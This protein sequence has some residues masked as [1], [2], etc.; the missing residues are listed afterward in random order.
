DTVFVTINQ[1]PSRPIIENGLDTL[2]FCK[3]DAPIWL[4]AVDTNADTTKTQLF[5]NNAS[6]NSDSLD[7]SIYP[8]GEYTVYSKNIFT[9]CVSERDTIMAY[10]SNSIEFQRF[11]DTINVCH[12]ETVNLEDEVVR[13]LANRNNNNYK[14]NIGHKIWALIGT[15]PN[16]LN[17]ATK[18]APKSIKTEKDVQRFY[19]EVLDSISGCFL[20]DTATVVF[21]EL[22]TIQQIDPIVICQFQDTLL[23][24]PSDVYKYEWFRKDHSQI[25][26]PEKLQL[27]KSE[28]IK[29]VA[30]DKEWGCV[31]S[32]FVK[33]DVKR[34]PEVALAEGE[35]FC[36][37]SGMHPIVAKINPSQDNAA[38]DLTIQWR[39]GKDVI[40]TPI[41]TDTIEVSGLSK[42]IHYTIRQTNKV[43]GCYKDTLIEV[44]VNRALR[45]AM[46]D[47]ERICQPDSIAFK[48]EVENYIYTNTADI[49]LP[50]VQDIQIEYARIDNGNAINLSD[51]QVEKLGYIEGRD[52]VAYIYT[53]TDA[54]KVCSASDT[55]FVTINQK[56]SRPIIENGSDT[57]FFCGDLAEI[58]I[59]AKDVNANPNE[60][61]IFWGEYAS[62]IAGDSLN[63]TAKE[64]RYTAF[65]QNIFTE[66]V[67]ELDTIVAVIS[68]PITV[69][70]IGNNGV[71]ELCAGEHINVADRG[72]ASFSIA[73]RWNSEVTFIAKADGNITNIVN[74]TDVTRTHQDTIV[75]EFSAID[76]LTGC[77]AQNT[78]TL[79]FH[80]KP[81]FEIEGSTILCQGDELSLNAIGDTR[82][83][84]YVWQFEGSDIVENSTAQFTKKGLMNDTTIMVIAQ[85]NGT[86]CIDTL[87]QLIKIHETPQT[88]ADQTFAFC[89]VNGNTTETILLERSEEDKA[90]FSLQW[91]DA[92]MQPIS[93]ENELSL[94]IANDTIYNLQVKQMNISK[95]IT[96]Q[97]ELSN[98]TVNVSKHINV[99]LRD[100]NICMP[101]RFNLAKYAKEGK[102]ESFSGYGLEIARIFKMEGATP[103]NVADSTQIE[104][105]GLYHI[106]Y[107]DNNSCETSADV[108][109]KFISKP[110]I[111]T[112]EESMP[113]Y[114][115]QGI[116][117][118]IS[119]KFIAGNYEY[120]WDKMGANET[121][122]SDSLKVNAA[123][124]NGSSVSYKVWRRDTIY[125]CESEKA[126]IAYQILDSI[127]TNLAETLH[128]CET[129]SIDLDSV[130]GH[131][132]TSNND[133]KMSIYHS[134]AT[135]KKGSQLLY[136][137]AVSEEGYYLIEAQDQ[138]SGCKAKNIVEIAK[139]AAPTLLFKGETSLCAGS[140]VR[141]I[142]YHK[143][144]EATPEYQWTDANNK[145][146]NDSILTFIAN[147]ETGETEAKEE[148]LVLTGSYHITNKKSC[149]SH[150][151]I[152]ITTH[153]IPPTLQN[154][155]IDICQNS[156]EKSI[157]VEYQDDVFNLK[158]FD[159]EGN[160]IA[161][162]IVN[163]DSVTNVRFTVMQEDRATGCMSKASTIFV[164]VRQSIELHIDE[165]AAV[166]APATIDLEKLVKKASM[167]SN[168]SI[169]E[170]KIYEI[171]NITKNGVEEE[172][173]NAI[174]QSGIYQV[175]IS[176]QYGC[177]AANAVQLNINQQPLPVSG[178]TSFCQGT[179]VQVLVGKGTSDN[180]I[181]EWLDLENAYPDSLFTDSLLIKTD[182]QGEK[183]FLVR[184]TTLNSHCSSDP[185]PMTVT[186]HPAIQ[187][188]LKDTTVCDGSLFDFEAYAQRLVSEGTEPY[189]FN[190][191]RTE[192]ILPIDYNAIRQGG[193]FIAHYK[194]VN[195]CEAK[196][197][198][199][200]TYAPKIEI[201]LNYKDEVC[202]GE[203]IVVKA[204]GADH[205][206]WNQT[207]N[208]MDSILIITEKEGI[209]EI[210]LTASNVINTAEDASCSIDTLIRIKVNK[211]PDLLTNYGDTA[212]CQNA[213]TEAL[214]LQ[215][216][217]PNAVVLWYDPNDNYE[218]VS[219]N[220]TLKPSSLYAGE[221]TYKFRQQ[222]DKCQ[223]MLQEYKV[224]IQSSIEE[225]AIVSDTSYC[226]DEAT[227]PLLAKWSNALYEVIWTDNR[228]NVLDP[229]FRPSSATAG[230]QE[231]QARLSYKA[232]QG[233]A[234]TLHITIQEKYDR[235]PNIN[236]SF[237]FCE[238][239]G[240]HTIKANTIDNGARLNWYAENSNERLDSIVIN[241]NASNWKSA[242]FFVTQSVINGCESPSS[243]F[244]VE[245]KEAIQPL[246]I[247]LD[248]CAGLN[249]SLAEI[250]AAHRINEKA[251][252]L[253]NGLD[254]SQRMDLNSNIGYTG[255]YPFSV[256]NEFGCKALHTAHINMMKVE[257]LEY[258]SIKNIYCYDDTVSLS[259]SSSNASIEWEN[260][261]EG[262]TH[263]GNDYN[264]ALNGA[265]D[266]TM[267]ATIINKP[268]CKET[269][270]FKFATFEKTEAAINGETN[271][272]L[273]NTISLN[274]SNLY[275]IKW[276]IADTT[277]EGDEFSFTPTQ[278]DI[279]SLT[280]VDRNQCPVKASVTI[281]TVKQPDP[282]IMVSPLIRSNIY[283]L[284]RDT[285]EVHLAA[286]ISSALDDNYSYRWD[287]GDGKTVYGNSEED[288]EYEPSLVRL[289]KP[290][291]VTLTVEHAY[292][293]VGEAKIKLLVDPDFDVPNTM[294][295]EDEFMEDYELQIFDRIGNLIYE[296]WGWHGQKN[297]GEDAFGDT[298]FYAITY[299]ING[300]KKIKTGY[301]TLVR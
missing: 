183:L 150:E 287:F 145:S 71:I 219:K 207:S 40:E 248:T 58:K 263:Y 3:D 237:I 293:C 107:S 198:M 221:Y 285:F 280:G 2:F 204:D 256:V 169:P 271:I 112:F 135:Q 114:L 117:T 26:A 72:K 7:I 109:I 252:T 229:D 6:S 82:A 31:D 157:M 29:L 214:S 243:T 64:K 17:D 16:T 86:A 92:D 192:P 93:N 235:V 203:T 24:A 292:G 28:N 32:I 76:K 167:E 246:S 77:E 260:V 241:T 250:M 110:E 218:T 62:A 230:Q 205:F 59:G 121:F 98:V 236:D 129:E 54:E 85:L 27:E 233:D 171:K 276:S 222:L 87:S 69:S 161:Q 102:V 11:A 125:G 141:L 73:Q 298:Y 33:M 13:R 127:R 60:T 55:V 265:M 212:Y 128:L 215:A 113:I 101:E 242:K 272:C 47:I 174:S 156:G 56:P 189:L 9:G 178:D 48:N 79:I 61:S 146:I 283:H 8:S 132:F 170:R 134:D 139:H 226:K 209:Q 163:T 104:A 251:D 53:V 284:N 220:G 67:S 172:R 217:D 286:A 216:S 153:P 278:S 257:D 57:L 34:I 185:A 206:V 130:A 176:D 152:K 266:V 238:N 46:D 193:R 155:T 173:P 234:S 194:D 43:T 50:N 268:V 227:A 158:R 12:N 231:Y 208:D 300:E 23:I 296:G 164:N 177:T 124:S 105:S 195:G 275:N 197:T 44:T 35:T 269:I 14:S 65:T 52:S 232:C 196:D 295:P 199:T 106:I 148:T 111:P 95:E 254:K 138:I 25:P 279:L 75:Y 239:T 290:I 140:E 288:H 119:P 202:A 240:N 154:D 108:N 225:R 45:L 10:I 224:N 115:C 245:I 182:K 144:G 191:R 184:Q 281:N 99:T 188:L 168:A 211:V 19:I 18:I 299:Y 103:S 277:A 149:D 187:P 301:I 1:K 179:G 142:A 210:G 88:L 131:L 36:Q 291:D 264:F 20:S 244:E 143:E 267:T 270:D 68:D 70:T 116:D 160:E 94:S 137:N 80:D 181:L 21:H 213:P 165:P 223:T 120:I 133:L 274:T 273:G 180:T 151:T 22:P 63:I 289:T 126:E 38:T 81:T 228:G 297:N 83:I 282:V 123:L 166:C 136:S 201:Q 249:I 89:Q 78:F 162:T 91:L 30:T 190:T 97:S 42:K 118:T 90:K 39:S 122:V 96:C 84:S 15:T 49:H 261:T 147:L 41:N 200:L 258:T 255:D 5:W 294:T 259:A 4:H 66:C 175:V 262:L 100:T 74:L 51:A 247:H 186:I 37:N 159:A 253:W